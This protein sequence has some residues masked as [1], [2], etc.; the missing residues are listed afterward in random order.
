MFLAGM[1]WEYFSVSTYEEVYRD[2]KLS[3]EVRSLS[4]WVLVELFVKEIFEFSLYMELVNVS[5]WDIILC[6]IC[7]ERW[8]AQLITY[9]KDSD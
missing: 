1:G 6:T 8:G 5:V 2:I 3:H 7:N 9:G 4:V